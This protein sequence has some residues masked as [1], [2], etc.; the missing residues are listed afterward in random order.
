MNTSMY[1]LYVKKIVEAFDRNPD[2]FTSWEQ[3]FIDDALTDINGNPVDASKLSVRQKEVVC[4][5]FDKI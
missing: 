5:I 3:E 1:Q 2:T 4:S